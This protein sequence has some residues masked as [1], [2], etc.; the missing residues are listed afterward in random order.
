MER[1]EWL[2]LFFADKTL[3]D[4]TLTSNLAKLATDLN[5]GD[6]DADTHT[7]AIES[8]KRYKKTAEE[9]HKETDETSS[10]TV[11]GYQL[12][13]EDK[14]GCTVT[15]RFDKVETSKRG[16]LLYN[17]MNLQSQV[18]DRRSPNRRSARSLWTS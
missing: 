1:I 11:S 18:W 3:N 7:A 9:F 6:W 5:L 4:H 10:E 8:I 17:A 15:K 2:R 12:T 16:K 14:S 13:Y